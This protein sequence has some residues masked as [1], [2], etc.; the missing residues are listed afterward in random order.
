MEAPI[1]DMIIDNQNSLTSSNF[2]ESNNEKEQSTTVNGEEVGDGSG[3]IIRNDV[4]QGSSPSSP[5]FI[6][7]IVLLLVGLLLFAITVGAFFGYPSNK[8]PKENMGKNIEK[9]RYPIG[10]VFSLVLIFLGAGF[11][12][13]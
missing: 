5:L 12:S 7:G 8:T 4:K 13:N 2:F 1:N 10:F 3:V 6:P 9:T 11:L